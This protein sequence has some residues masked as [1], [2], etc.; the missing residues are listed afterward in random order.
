MKA[1]ADSNSRPL[2]VT[3]LMI[4]SQMAIIFILKL[5]SS[6]VFTAAFN[7]HRE[8]QTESTGVSFR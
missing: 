5:Q 4:I 1:D 6:E 3:P 8:G 7:A 2:E